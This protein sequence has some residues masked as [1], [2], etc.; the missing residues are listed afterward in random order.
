MPSS[1]TIARLRD[2]TNLAE[3]GQYRCNYCRSTK[4]L[5][6]GIVVTWG[7][8]VFFALCPECFPGRP[9]TIEEATLSSGKPGIRVGF[10]NSSDAPL[11]QLVRGEH[12]ARTFIASQALAE[13]QKREIPD[14]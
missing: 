8:Q 12:E 10:K 5:A 11:V 6:D 13:R 1:S 7:G 9:V 3:A 2:A 14:E 4:P